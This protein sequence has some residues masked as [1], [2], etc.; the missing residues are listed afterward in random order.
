MRSAR[1]WQVIAMVI[2]LYALPVDTAAPRLVTAPIFCICIWEQTDA[3]WQKV[4]AVNNGPF[5]FFGRTVT[6]ACEAEAI[7]GL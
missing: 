6:R 2:A 5:Y 7:D 3:D 4:M 1:L